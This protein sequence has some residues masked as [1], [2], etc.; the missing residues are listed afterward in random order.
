MGYGVGIE[1][2]IKETESGYILL[3]DDDNVLEPGALAVLMKAHAEVANEIPIDRLAVL[4]FRPEHQADLAAGLPVERAEH[5]PNSFFGF[6][7]VDIPFKLLRRMPWVMRR[8]GTRPLPQ[9]VR[10]R[11]GP[12]S[13]LLF[14]R[15]VVERVGTPNPDLVLYAD[16]TEFTYRLTAIG[17]GIWLIPGAR[18]ADLESSWNAKTRFATSFTGWLCGEGDQRA[19]YGA[20]NQAY[21]EGHCRDHN[22]LVRGLNQA[23]Y[24]ALLALMA[25]RLRRMARL[26]LLLNAIRDGSA[27]HLGLHPG[28]PLG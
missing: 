16:D 17:G 2:A 10:V 26:R 14:H 24:L 22:P 15:A 5:H 18:L 8:Y 13:G 4:G 19:Y 11:T 3:L 9:R 23:V 21:F 12:Y 25:V 7:V 1:A 6:H 20:R 27:G 28:F